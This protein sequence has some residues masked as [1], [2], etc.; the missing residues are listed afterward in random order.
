MVEEIR[1]KKK[2]A[3]KILNKNHVVA[4]RQSEHTMSERHILANTST[5]PFVVNLK[6]AYRTD[7]TL[8]LVMDY[9][10]GGVK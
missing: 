3:M 10:P 5:H 6:F 9:C 2:Y 4:K 1:T 7:T 8:N